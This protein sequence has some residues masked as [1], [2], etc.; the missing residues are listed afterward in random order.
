MGGA[1]IV[2]ACLAILRSPEGDALRSR[3]ARNAASCRAHLHARGFEVPG[4]TSPIVPVLLGEHGLVRLAPKHK[5]QP[6]GIVNLVEYPGVS[7][8]TTG[9]RLQVTA[10][11]REKHLLH[12]ADIACEARS[13]STAELAHLTDGVAA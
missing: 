3:L 8:N 10:S 11:H 9:W 6:G 4:Q 7:R 5:L 12:M 13:L 1:H 2:L